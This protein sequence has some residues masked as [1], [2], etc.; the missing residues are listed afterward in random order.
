MN[1]GQDRAHSAFALV[2]EEPTACIPLITLRPE[3]EVGRLEPAHPRVEHG[4][5]DRDIHDALRR[6]G[7][8]S[9]PVEAPAKHAA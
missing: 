9:Q 2:G 3:R 8:R 5:G 1:L 4:Q 6:V 7:G